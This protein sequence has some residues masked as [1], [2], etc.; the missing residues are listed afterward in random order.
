M[1]QCRA[2][3][4]GIGIG[5]AD[6]GNGVLVIARVI[7]RREQI[8]AAAAFADIR[9]LQDPITSSIEQ[10]DDRGIGTRRFVHVIA[11]LMR[12]IGSYCRVLRYAPDRIAHFAPF[13]RGVG[14]LEQTAIGEAVRGHIQYA[15]D[16][17]LVEALVKD[18]GGTVQCQTP[19]VTFHVTQPSLLN[20]NNNR[21]TPH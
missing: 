13:G 17:R 14:V 11:P 9:S 21:V 7:L 15:H 12:P 4:A 6:G 5:T 1:S 2:A 20:P 18:S 19:P 10:I 3:H 8:R 16:L